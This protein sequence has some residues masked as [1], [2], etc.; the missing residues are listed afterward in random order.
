MSD[1][2]PTNKVAGILGR[3]LPKAQGD[4]GVSCS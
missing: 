4:H 3:F 1:D 2:A